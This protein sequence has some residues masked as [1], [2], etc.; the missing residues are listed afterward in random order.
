MDILSN[1][2]TASWPSYHIV[3]EWEDCISQQMGCSIKTDSVLIVNQWMKR[4]N[5][6]QDSFLPKGNL[7]MYEVSINSDPKEIRRYN[8]SNIV[9]CVVDYFFKDDEIDIFESKFSRHP[10]V[11]ISSME[12]YLRLKSLGCRLNI[13][14]LPLSLSDIYAIDE[15]TTFEKR[16]DLVMMGRQNNVLKEFLDIYIKTH[17]DFLYVYEDMTKGKLHYSSSD[18]EYIGYI[19]GRAEYMKLLRQSKVAMY[20]TPGIDGGE[21]RTNGYNQ[22]TPKFLEF[23]ASGCNIIARWKDNPDT[24][25]YHLKEF[26]ENVD[27]YA[28][29]ERLMNKYRE[30]KADIAKY[31]QYLRR[32]YTSTLVTTINNLG[33]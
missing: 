11:F 32:H 13:K 24:D 23:L 25:F 20:S 1:R 22:V 19:S 12:V 4:F 18:G 26:S 15:N 6:F 33:L 3:W 5:L 28:S 16:Y 7:F 29:F 21:K 30:E 17:P 2:N 10:V 9:P 27:S 14:H 8:R 31:S